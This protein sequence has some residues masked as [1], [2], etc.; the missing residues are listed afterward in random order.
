MMSANR[1]ADL[2]RKLALA[3]VPRPPAGLAERIKREI[4]KQLAIQDT[5]LERRR[6]SS[7]VAFNMRVAASILLL[8]SSVYLCLNILSRGE[9]ENASIEHAEKI[10]NA[11]E[12]H[13]RVAPVAPPPVAKTAA[14]NDAAGVT[15]GV[16]A[17]APQVAEKKTVA[18]ERAPLVA[19]AHTEQLADNE[20]AKPKREETQ[21]FVKVE[22]TP[23]PAPAP[24]PPPPLADA[25]T[26]EAP[27]VTVPAA[28]GAV[29]GEFVR[30][31][32][33]ADLA[34]GLPLT[35]F[36]IDV[37]THAL[38]K[39]NSAAMLVGRFAATAQAPSHGIRVEADIAPSPF[40]ATKQLLRVSI[41]MPSADVAPH[42]SVPPVASDAKLTIDI[43]EKNVGTRKPL[44][45][46]TSNEE[47][48]L[49]ANSS[50]TALYEIEIDPQ[51]SR[52]AVLATVELRY[53]SLKTGKMET[54]TRTI[55]RSSVAE[56][57]EKASKRMK[58]ASLAASIGKVPADQLAEKA[59][60]AGLDELAAAV[61]P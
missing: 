45:G 17:A 23:A 61:Q 26:A 9:K 55:R 53:K 35:L 8:I 50:V 28:A 60:A 43:D 56:S 59:K 13:A 42:S 3:P 12:S 58:A 6:F 4:P 21:D 40:D 29:P 27:V 2:Q 15:S 1:K 10:L 22:P 47:H 41:D 54:I 49:V 31:A 57:W 30:S 39:G 19:E 52:R 48:V 20:V 25:Q 24:P 5:E 36:G 7:A 14:A 44:V 33:A 34:L 37:A 18:D 51:A 11:P 46:V 16:D 38:A 32:K